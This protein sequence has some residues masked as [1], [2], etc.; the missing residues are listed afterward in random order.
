[1]AAPPFFSSY[2]VRLCE[3]VHTYAIGIIRL[4]SDPQI[5]FLRKVVQTNFYFC[6]FQTS[7]IL[8]KGKGVVAQ[9]K[10]RSF[11]LR[12]HFRLDDHRQSTLTMQEGLLRT[13]SEVKLRGRGVKYRGEIVVKHLRGG[14]ENFTRIWRRAFGR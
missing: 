2:R 1:M 5:Y 12:R 10:S 11:Y 4:E 13:S 14:W 7:G 8:S 9:P 6:L 3:S